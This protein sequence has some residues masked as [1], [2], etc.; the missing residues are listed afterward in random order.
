LYVDFDCSRFLSVT[1]VV[2]QQEQ[3]EKVDEIE[4][5]T[6]EAEENVKEGTSLLG[7]AARYRAVAYP[8]AGAVLGGC[9]GGPVGLLAG[10][11]IGGLAALGCGFIGKHS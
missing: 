10:I 5:N 3:K 11:K 9:L 4:Y 7:R 8:V 1:S 2:L 6:V